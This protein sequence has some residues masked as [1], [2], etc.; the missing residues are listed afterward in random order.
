MIAARLMFLPWSVAQSSGV[1]SWAMSD[2]VRAPRD[3]SLEYGSP[4]SLCLS[5]CF[6]AQDRPRVGV[7]A[8]QVF[9]HILVTATLVGDQRGNYVSS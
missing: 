3:L 1:P 7:E 5:F 9:L 2:L 6:G 4:A 8:S